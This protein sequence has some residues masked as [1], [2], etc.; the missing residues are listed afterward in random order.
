MNFLFTEFA[1][2]HAD[3]LLQ[4]HI[5]HAM[6]LE[7]LQETGAEEHARALEEIRAHIVALQPVN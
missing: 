2:Q 4:V 5:M 6:M 3:T 1:L 7:R